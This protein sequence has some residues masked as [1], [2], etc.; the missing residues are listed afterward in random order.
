MADNGY[1]VG[2]FAILAI[3]L[4]RLAIGVQFL[5]AGLE[6]LEPGFSSEYFLRSA[7]GPLSDYYR[8]MAPAAHYWDE[9]GDE[10][11]PEAFQFEHERRYLGDKGEIQDKKSK[12]D[13]IGFIPY[14]TDAYGPWYANVAGDWYHTS[15]DLQ[16][17]PGLSDEQQTALND[18][19]EK[20][21]RQLAWLA[22]KQRYEIEEWRHELDRLDEL[23][24]S[25]EAGEVAY[26][27]EWIDDWKGEAARDPR[28]WLEDVEGA[29]AAYYDD[30]RSVFTEEQLDSS[31]LLNRVE[32]TLNPPTKLQKIDKVVTY[33]TLTV[34]VLLI[35]GLF[36]RLAS[37]AAAAFLVSV[38]STQPLW[39]AGVPDMA[40]MIFPYQGIEVA[41]LLVLAGIG[42][43]TWAGLD[44][45]LFRRKQTES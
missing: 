19:F 28:P 1:R 10:P 38:M 25:D 3:V 27:D 40:K 34:G 44:G 5:V 37:V 9:L 13:E 17:M 16:A 23:K 22:E 45:L 35:F 26:V 43:G 18:A 21:Y 24:N 30:L 31:T 7:N 20:N 14:P 29:E 15:T 6:K 33:F 2:A 42:A 39:S 12:I 4:L 8:S 41:A 11:W 36:A 32:T